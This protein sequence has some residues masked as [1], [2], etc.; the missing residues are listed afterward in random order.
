ME[1]C[2]LYLSELFILLFEVFLPATQIY[3]FLIVPSIRASSSFLHLRF[4][5]DVK[6]VHGQSEITKFRNSTSIVCKSH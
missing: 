1:G 6:S 2:P 4:E 3:W 5:A